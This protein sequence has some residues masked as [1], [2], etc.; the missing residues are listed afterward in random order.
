MTAVAREI[1]SK[2]QPRRGL[3]RVEILIGELP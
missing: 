1:R 3:R 2:S